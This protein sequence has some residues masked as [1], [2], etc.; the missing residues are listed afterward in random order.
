MASALP[1][2]GL[3]FLGWLMQAS[4]AR[5]RGAPSAC[6]LRPPEVKPRTSATRPLRLLRPRVLST[7]ASANERSRPVPAAQEA[8]AKPD[9]ASFQS[10]LGV[11]RASPSLAP[12]LLQQP[13][14]PVGNGKAPPHA[15]DE[16][17]G[18]G[19]TGLRPRRCPWGAEPR[20]RQRAG[21]GRAGLGG[22]L[23]APAHRELSPRAGRGRCRAPPRLWGLTPPPC[24]PS[25][26]AA[27][28]SSPLFGRCGCAH[29]G[30]SCV[31]F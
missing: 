8:P 5:C 17:W 18:R 22:A 27:V 24:P 25:L 30:E 10:G 26:T 7:G 16:P 29:R 15:P 21:P 28:P 19:A 4:D 1:Q 31:N 13:R 2:R 20:G 11:A 14:L 3:I 23:A 9:V 12:S 6:P